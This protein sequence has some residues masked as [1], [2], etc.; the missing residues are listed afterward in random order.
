M[1]SAKPSSP[2]LGRASACEFL[3]RTSVNTILEYC[4]Y[5]S[6]SRAVPI[7]EYVCPKCG[8]AFERRVT[9]ADADVAQECP[10][11]GHERA[12]KQISLFA[13]SSSGGTGSTAQAD[14]GPVG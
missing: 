4:E 8:E 3:T 12:E 13:S 9:F 5:R 2:V 1:P 7:Y 11:C 14:C 10:A 6:W